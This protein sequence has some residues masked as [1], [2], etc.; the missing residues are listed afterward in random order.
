MKLPNKL[1]ISDTLCSLD[2]RV[3]Q[4]FLGTVSPFP[5]LNESEMRIIVVAA[6]SCQTLFDLMDCSTSGLSVLYYLLEFAQSH[7]H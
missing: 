2:F 5:S 3:E 1:D 4:H 7:V 6:Q